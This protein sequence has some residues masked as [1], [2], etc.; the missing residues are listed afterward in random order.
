M[1]SLVLQMSLSHTD[2]NN[3]SFG[4][5]RFARRA[6]FVWCGWV[7]PGA[8]GPRGRGEDTPIRRGAVPPLPRG[9]LAPHQPRGWGTHDARIERAHGDT[10]I[11]PG[12]GPAVRWS[13]TG[14]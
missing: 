12:H 9:P 8:T 14:T 2:S 10:R 13:E 6:N 7:D 5:V 3:M 1:S 11:W 4:R